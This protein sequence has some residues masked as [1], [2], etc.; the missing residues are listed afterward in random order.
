MAFTRAM[1]LAFVLGAVAQPAHSMT[2]AEID[3]LVAAGMPPLT[4][5]RSPWYT[6]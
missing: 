1:I 4:A 3:A 5:C 6:A 2:R